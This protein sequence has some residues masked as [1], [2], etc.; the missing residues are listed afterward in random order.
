ML[1]VC[2]H[3]YKIRKGFRIDVIILNFAQ[4][5]KFFKALKIEKAITFM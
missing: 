3:V 4:K 2:M 1:R 5:C